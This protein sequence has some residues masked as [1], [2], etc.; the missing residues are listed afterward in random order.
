MVDAYNALILKV[1]TV[2]SEKYDSDYP[3][4][5]DAQKAEMTTTEI[6]LWEEKAKT[7][8][9]ANDSDLT[10]LA[11]ELRTIFYERGNFSFSF[12]DIGITTSS[13]YADNGK[14]TF[15]RSAFETALMQDSDTVCEMFTSTA[16][17]SSG[18]SISIM[19]QLKTIMDKYAST[20]GATKGILIEK[21]G[22]ESAPTSL[23][24]NTLLSQREAID[25]LLEAVRYRLEIAEERYRSQFTALEV[26][27]SE[28]NAQS[29][30]LYD[31]MGNM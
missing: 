5:T 21:A 1:N 10:F 16:T 20:T 11:Q 9:L 13:N 3:P 28:M 26:Y 7:G 24:S 12:E 22:H 27:I 6:E 25:E 29:S 30:W 14:L 4:L 23:L 2:I 15:D 17:D 31:Q 18:A 19:E 8:I